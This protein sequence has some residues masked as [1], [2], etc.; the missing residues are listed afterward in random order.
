MCEASFEELRADEG[1]R[2]VGQHLRS[3]RRD[4]GWGLADLAAKTKISMETLKWIEAGREDDL[5]DRVFVRG[6]V[7]CCARAMELDGDDLVE[8]LADPLPAPKPLT[9]GQKLRRAPA[10]VGRWTASVPTVKQGSFAVYLS[11]A[12][13]VVFVTLFALVSDFLSK[14]TMHAL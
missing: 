8:M 10:S 2:G 5:P 9:A 1:L 3:R 14:G 11:L 4:L 7:R 12:L 6:F 13:L